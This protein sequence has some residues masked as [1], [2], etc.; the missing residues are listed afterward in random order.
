[1][2]FDTENCR[3]RIVRLTVNSTDLGDF[4]LSPGGDT[5]YYEAR[6][7]DGY[8]LWKHEMREGKTTLVMKKSMAD[9]C[10]LTVPSSIFS[11]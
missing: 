7:E 9:I 1:M 4:I 3:D 5:L 8:D 6:Y 10:R 11:P 2:R